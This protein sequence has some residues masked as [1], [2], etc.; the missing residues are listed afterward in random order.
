MAKMGDE[1]AA[2]QQLCTGGSNPTLSAANILLHY[3]T[4]EYQYARC[5]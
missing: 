5:P 4:I 1:K 2:S 3:G